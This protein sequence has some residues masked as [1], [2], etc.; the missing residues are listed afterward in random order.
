MFELSGVF[1]GKYLL[2]ITLIFNLNHVSTNTAFTFFISTFDRIVLPN[3]DNFRRILWYFFLLNVRVSMKFV[4]PL[5]SKFYRFFF[6]IFRIFLW[7]SAKYGATIIS[8]IERA[9]QFFF[10]LIYSISLIRAANHSFPI[11]FKK[12]KNRRVEAIK[13]NSNRESYSP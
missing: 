12:K 6:I 2:S 8:T 13:K 1:T 11:L 5:H 7:I 10:M 4:E 9:F 3:S